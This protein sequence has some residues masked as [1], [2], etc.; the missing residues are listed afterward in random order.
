MKLSK[1]LALGILIGLAIATLQIPKAEAIS[2]AWN[3]ESMNMALPGKRVAER[4]TAHLQGKS[5]VV[6]VNSGTT[7]ISVLCAK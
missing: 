3:C 2:G 7:A 6:V 4:A 1:E 5:Q